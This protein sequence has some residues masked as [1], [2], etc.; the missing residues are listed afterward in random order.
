MSLRTMA[1]ARQ[2]TCVCVC[3]GGG[4]LLVHVRENYG[5]CQTAHFL[6]QEMCVVVRGGAIGACP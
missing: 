4:G 5:S 6:A 2:H 1:V 3:V